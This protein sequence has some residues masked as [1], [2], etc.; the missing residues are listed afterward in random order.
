MSVKLVKKTGG[1]SVGEYS[2]AKDGDVVEVDDDLAAELLSIDPDE[3]SVEVEKKAP[4]KKAAASKS[5]G[6]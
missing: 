5:D 6:E 1:S 2:W 3:F 4:A